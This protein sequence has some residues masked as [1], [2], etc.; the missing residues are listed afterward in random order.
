MPTVIRADCPACGAENHPEAETCVDCG[1]P[2]SAVGR[3]FGHAAKPTQPRWLDEARDRAQALKDEDRQP[4]E[5]R[6]QTFLDIDRRREAYQA[7][8]AARQRQRDRRL[9]Q[10]MAVGLGLFLIVV[11]V[12]TLFNLYP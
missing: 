4:S 12:I 2:L 7:E 8:S 6:M 1:E 10:A 5:E 11:V 3:I 9:L